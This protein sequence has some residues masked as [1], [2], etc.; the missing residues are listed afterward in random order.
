MEIKITLTEAE[1]K[2]MA[3]VAYDVQEWAE[4]AVHERARIAMDE[5]FQVEVQRMLADPNT[6]EIPADREAVVL[7]ADIQSAAERQVQSSLETEVEL[8][9]L[10]LSE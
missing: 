4:N 3:Y 9:G 8:D 5:I 6:N 7:S 10:G 1:A 2:A